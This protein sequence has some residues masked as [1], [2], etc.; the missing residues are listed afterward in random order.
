MVDFSKQDIIFIYGRIKTELYQL[1]IINEMLDDSHDVKPLNQDVNILRSIT[2][3]IETEFPDCLDDV[4]QHSF[5]KLA[6]DKLFR[7]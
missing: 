1:E 3:K 2:E 5:R 4:L 7:T 6:K